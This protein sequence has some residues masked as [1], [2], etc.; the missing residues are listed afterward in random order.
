MADDMPKMSD[1]RAMQEMVKAI[2][3]LTQT[4]RSE[5]SRRDSRDS[6][7]HRAQMS[8]HGETHGLLVKL[9]SVDEPIKPKL[10]NGANDREH[11][12]RHELLGGLAVEVSDETARRA[13][14]TWAIL[15]FVAGAI[16]LAISAGGWILHYLGRK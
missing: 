15:K 12:G 6:E 16:I 3:T 7:R 11:T 8:A 13:I 1:A 5:G 14:N 2:I 9:V 10:V 4:L